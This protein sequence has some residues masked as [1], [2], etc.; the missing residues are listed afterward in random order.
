METKNLKSIAIGRYKTT[1]PRK[2]IVLGNV[3]CI[4]NDFQNVYAV[5]LGGEE[6]ETH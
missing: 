6:L 3:S 1:A 4:Y 5:K 2:R